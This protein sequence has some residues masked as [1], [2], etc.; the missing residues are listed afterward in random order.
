MI[1]QSMIIINAIEQD[2]RVWSFLKPVYIC[3]GIEYWISS[4]SLFQSFQQAGLRQ[5][6]ETKH[7][8]IH[9]HLKALFLIPGHH[10]W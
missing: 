5:W 4:D 9:L 8:V 2:M 6:L 3:M 1:L 10:T 7:E